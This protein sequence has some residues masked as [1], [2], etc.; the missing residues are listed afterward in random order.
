MD[1]VWGFHL[2]RLLSSFSLWGS[3]FSSVNENNAHGW[4]GGEI[5][6]SSLGKDSGTYHAR[7]ISSFPL[8]P[9]ERPMS[10]NEFFVCLFCFFMAAPVAHG[11][12]RC[13]SKWLFGL[14]FIQPHS[15]GILA[16]DIH[17]DFMLRRDFCAAP[18]PGSA[19][20]NAALPRDAGFFQAP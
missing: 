8:H 19:H 3:V 5:Q 13:P 10:T 17:W 4:G 14:V 15:Q 9:K 11:S 16:A 18:H 1:C 7:Q 20:E 6:S 12:S 2:A